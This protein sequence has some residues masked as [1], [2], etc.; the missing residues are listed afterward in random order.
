MPDHYDTIGVPRDASAEDIE[1]AFRK[2]A[3]TAHPD[4]GGT[5]E[6]MAELN[7]ARA[8]LLDRDRRAR[9][10][11][12]ETDQD[13]QPSAD[14]IAVELL[15]QLFEAALDDDRNI[16][17]AAREALSRGQAELP[18]E[19]L[20]LRQRLSKLQRRRELIK[21]SD[22][23]DNIAH[24]ILANKM[25][26]I[27]RELSAITLKLAVVTRASEMLGAY[28]D[29]QARTTVTEESIRDTILRQMQRQPRGFGFNP[30]SFT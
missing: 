14:S 25:N 29:E 6:R 24:L 15:R 1:K 4:L 9:Y 20:V 30:S 28:S 7:A 11:K 12:G 22:G 27:N 5:P 13:S 16:V 17:E 3:R 26:A 23:V 8:V 21:A 18:S 2:A 10:D 19:A